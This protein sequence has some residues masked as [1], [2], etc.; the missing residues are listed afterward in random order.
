MALSC[1]LACNPEWNI[2]HTVLI[3]CV[4]L[5]ELEVT[6]LDFVAYLKGVAAF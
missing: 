4:N 1:A 3:I 6:T 2:A 5:C